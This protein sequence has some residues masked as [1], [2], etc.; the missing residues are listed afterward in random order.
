MVNPQLVAITMD[1]P[2][3]FAAFSSAP[4]WVVGGNIQC[5]TAGATITSRSGGASSQAQT[6]AAGDVMSV[7]FLNLMDFLA[8]ETV[9]GAGAQLVFFGVIVESK[10]AMVQTMVGG[11]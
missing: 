8:K 3:A 1:V 9:G 4:V 11:R 5:L 6:L 2:D 7:A 10:D